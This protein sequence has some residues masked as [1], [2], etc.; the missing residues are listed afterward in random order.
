VGFG[1]G[2]WHPTWLVFMIVP[3]VAVFQERKTMRFMAF[4][5][6]VSPLVLTTLYLGYGLLYGVWHP[7]WLIL[8]LIPI[9]G[10]TTGKSSMTWTE[11]L[12]ALSPIVI[13]G[14]YLGYGFTHNVW[15]PTWLAFWI[16]PILGLLTDKDNPKSWIFL[17]AILCSVVVYFYM[18]LNDVSRYSWLVL[19][20][21]L[22][23]G[24]FTG[25]VS[26]GLPLKKEGAKLRDKVM[27]YLSIGTIV[28]YLLIGLLFNWWHPG[29]LIFLVIPVV[30]IILYN[31]ENE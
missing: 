22:V 26:I 20:A 25:Y 10:I 30:S 23:I 29:W 3:I 24:Y 13:V 28:V 12:V 15:H 5:T 1:F 8:L 2:I 7:T 14:F 17:V 16:I 31:D 18:D 11:F 6:A 9:F 27:A 21:P 4:L 19:V